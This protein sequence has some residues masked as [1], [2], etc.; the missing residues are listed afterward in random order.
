MKAKK[1]CPISLRHIVYVDFETGKRYVF[2]TN[3]FVLSASFNIDTIWVVNL[4]RFI[5]KPPFCLF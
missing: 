1:E 3:H 5:I 4:D 2:L